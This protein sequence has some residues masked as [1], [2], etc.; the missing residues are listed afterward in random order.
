MPGDPDRDGLPQ[1]GLRRIEPAEAAVVRRIFQEYAAG[2][3]AKAIAQAL[4]REE[5]AGPHGGG[6]GPSTV[7]GNAA[8]GSGIL[9]NELYVGRL[10][11]NRL[12][13]V[14]DPTPESGSRG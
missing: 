1:R 10:V 14:K 8:R 4:N 13:Y 9:N 3:S 7:A 5:I 2:R 12:R 11:W 6:W